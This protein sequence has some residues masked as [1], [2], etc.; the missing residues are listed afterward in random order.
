MFDLAL[1]MGAILAIVYGSKAVK[2]N[3]MDKRGNKLIA[4]G[5]FL[6]M[7]ALPESCL[8][9]LIAGWIQIRRWYAGFCSEPVV[10]V[11]PTSTKNF[12]R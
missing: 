12:R 11:L 1:L 2:R 9:S 4:G 5:V 8:V 7:W 10:V 6:L 3:S